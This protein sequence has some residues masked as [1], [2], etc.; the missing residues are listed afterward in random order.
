MKLLYAALFLCVSI[1]LS[2]NQP[3]ANTLPTHLTNNWYR[4]SAKEL[5]RQISQL[6][7]IDN[8]VTETPIC[9]LVVPHATYQ[10]SGTVAARGYYLAAQHMVTRIII[11]ATSHDPDDQNIHVPLA[12]A[13]Q[14]PLGPVAIDSKAADIVRA[15]VYHNEIPKAGADD[16]PHTTDWYQQEHSLEIQLPLIKHYF[17]ATP[18]VPIYVGHLSP[19]ARASLAETLESI[20]TDETLVV[21][22]SDF[23]HYGPDYRYRPFS[24]SIQENIKALDME[25]VDILLHKDTP[26]WFDFLE[27]TNATICG[28]EPLA[29]FLELRNRGTWSYTYPE[30]IAYDTSGA[31]MNDFT[32]SVSY[33]SVCLHNYSISSAQKADLLTR[34][35]SALTK[36]LRT[37]TSDQPAP[38]IQPSSH[39]TMLNAHLGA[40]VTLNTINPDGSKQLRGCVGAIAPTKPLYE[41]VKDFTTLATRN[42]PRFAPVTSDELDTIGITISVLTPAREVTSAKQIVLGR[43]GLLLIN[44]EEQAEALFLP[45]VP[46]EQHFTLTQTLEELSLKAGLPQN[47]YLLAGTR[48]STFQTIS[49]SEAAPR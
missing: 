41:T 25:A 31:Q 27:Q 20:I 43:D 14:T 7:P 10:Y 49:W 8:P 47:G 26:D 34:S 18:I 5:I 24:V 15:S 37:L 6:N 1:T 13:Y 46:I 40:F 19:T 23:T 21:I 22:S 2:A 11:L 3:S 12:T 17:P 32:N 9:A 30:L 4:Q 39:D 16:T 44:E 48:L 42:D 35:R 29:L 45:E 36:A 28:K 33:L 38:T